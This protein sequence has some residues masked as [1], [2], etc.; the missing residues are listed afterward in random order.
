[1]GSEEFIDVVVFFQGS[2]AHLHPTWCL[3]NCNVGEDLKFLNVFQGSPESDDV[4]NQRFRVAI[5]LV[6]SIQ[7]I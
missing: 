4:L 6:A 5:E 3:R 7:Q 1:M 2:F